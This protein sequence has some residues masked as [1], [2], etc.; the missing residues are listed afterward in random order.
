MPPRALLLTPVTRR[1]KGSMQ[2]KLFSID[3]TYREDDQPAVLSLGM[4][5]KNCWARVVEESLRR[6]DGRAPPPVSRRVF[7]SGPSKIYCC[8]MLALRSCLSTHARYVVVPAAPQSDPVV[9]KQDWRLV[10]VILGLALLVVL[11]A[12]MW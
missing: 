8:Q 7:R 3:R 12:V 10:A 2:Q 9:Y 11:F 4:R 6:L 5:L 1:V